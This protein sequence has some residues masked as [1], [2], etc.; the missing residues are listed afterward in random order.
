MS[1]ARRR[2]PA[3][4]RV[5]PAPL[6]GEDR[7]LSIAAWAVAGALLVALVALIAGP[8]SVGDYFTESDFYGAYAQGARA[9]QHGHLDPTRYGVVGPG[10][11]VALALAGFVVRDLF[12]AAELLSALATT[13]IL[14]LWF[15]I[16]RRL[17]DA[18]LAL[19]AV[20]FL[21]TNATLV[22]YGD[23]ATT[24][25]LAGAL[26]AAALAVLLVRR[27]PRAPLWAG[28]LAA[29][30][31]L[32][33]YTAIALLPAG[34]LAI[35]LGAAGDPRRGRAALRYTIGFLAPVVPWVAFSLARGGT[36]SF[37]LHHNI[38]YDVFAR[39]RGLTWDEY[40]QRLQSQ[41]PTLWSVIARDPAAVAGRMLFNV[42][43]H[44]RL[45]A[46]R[47]AGIPV[48]IASAAGL[49]LAEWD[50][51]A[52]RLAPVWIAAGLV[53]LALVP[54]FHSSRYSLL[55][56]PAWA[57]LA[58]AAFTSPRLSPSVRRVPVLAAVALVP[59]AFSLRA[60]VAEERRT[61]D[62]L[63]REARQA[64]EVLRRLARPGDVVIA[65]KAHVAY[66]GGVRAAPFPFADSL[67]ALAADA[68]A[69]H[70]RWLFYSWPEAELR[71]R[72]RHLLDTTG[73]V[74]GL[75]V[76]FS[77][78]PRPAVL[79]EIGPGFG[80]TPAWYANDTLFT[81]HDALGALRVNA[82]D[83]VALYRAGLAENALGR[84]PE[85]R[86]HLERAASVTPGD[87][88]VWLALGRACLAANDVSAGRAAYEHAEKLA[89]HSA[90]ARIGRGRAALMGGDLR[91]AAEL[92]R[93]VVDLADDSGTLTRMVDLYR[94]VGDRATAARAAA[95]LRAVRG[96]R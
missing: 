15:A 91:G 7:A 16:V 74:P 21:A 13:A 65:R 75:T 43:D 90:D 73:V 94:A 52:R 4:A 24:D 79:Y 34:L 88:K 93:P 6:P 77:A 62:Q 5:P 27:G 78:D 96:S 2:R 12:L 25:A 11:E 54:A 82:F 59:L 87:P 84:I 69:A 47:L 42:Y 51:R 85:A 31:F 70:A 61:L 19:G 9:L 30:A 86:A 39:A 23:A 3:A 58:A 32:T 66:Y 76:R 81:W 26:V 41:F 29:A 53:F 46:V 28:L 44:A 33:R 67:A 89:P 38:A 80:R 83:P 37:Q 40:Q 45:D 55:V 35:A 95:R 60:T 20:L 1:R 68:R 50:G 72:F 18:R 63:P 56:L 17:A 71:P 36:L 48:A 14:M 22:R 57:I 92:W 10:Y 49:A 8:H 64:G